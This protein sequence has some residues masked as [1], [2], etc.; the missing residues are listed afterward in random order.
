MLKGDAHWKNVLLLL[1]ESSTWISV[2]GFEVYYLSYCFLSIK[3]VGFLWNCLHI[4]WIK[5]KYFPVKHSTLSTVWFRMGRFWFVA[6]DYVVLVMYSSS[7]GQ[8]G[9]SGLL[10]VLYLGHL[11]SITILIKNLILNCFNFMQ[12]F[13]KKFLINFLFGA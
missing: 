3:C 7:R 10:S 11:K 13:W 1:P 5:N 12:A 9:Q 6:W 8:S 4:K 2:T